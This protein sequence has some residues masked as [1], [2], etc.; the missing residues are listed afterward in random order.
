MQ[1]YPFRSFHGVRA[2]RESST[3]TM[4]RLLVTSVLAIATLNVANA[5][6]CMFGAGPACE[7]TWRKSVDAAFV[8]QVEKIELVQGIP[9]APTGAMSMTMRGG[10]NRVTVAVQEAYRGVSARTVVVYTASSSAACG[11]EFQEQERYLIFAS[12]SKDGQLTVSLC[13]AT[14]PAQYAAEDIS[15]LRS[16]PSLKPTSTI[17]GSVWRYTHDPNFRPKFQPSLMDHYR[18]PEQ[19][20]MAMKPEPG[21]RVMAKGQDG[22]ERTAIVDTDGNWRISDLSPGRYTVEP[23]T[24]EGV[25]IYPFFSNLDVRITSR[26]NLGICRGWSHAT[27]QWSRKPQCR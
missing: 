26:D 8:G 23:Q 3:V 6:T 24:R 2:I 13:S 16:L 5:C 12:A 17:R 21:I 19:D 11:F 27:S 20:Y 25:Y 7:E 1:K 18:P 10:Q 15:Y 4:I 14:K 22:I 9:P